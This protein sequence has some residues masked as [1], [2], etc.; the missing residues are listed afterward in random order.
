MVTHI[1]LMVKTNQKHVYLL[2]QTQVIQLH[3]QKS[4]EMLE[5]DDEH[6]VGAAL[7]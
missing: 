2:A 4:T 7:E 5:A 6:G 1:L 3:A